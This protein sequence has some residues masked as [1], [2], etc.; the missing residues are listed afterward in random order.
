M[1]GRGTDTQT[2]G[3]S[4]QPETDPHKHAQLILTKLQKQVSG[5][6]TAFSTDSTGETAHPHKEKGPPAKPREIIASK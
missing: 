2:N 4:T 3:Q 5:E 1:Q 6:K